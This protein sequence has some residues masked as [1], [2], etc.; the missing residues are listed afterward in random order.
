MKS[1]INRFICLIVG[2]R[3]DSFVKEDELTHLEFFFSKCIRC[4]FVAF[5]FKVGS[6]LDKAYKKFQSHEPAKVK[7]GSNETNS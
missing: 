1:P 5:K 7:S 2:H 3:M 4:G 6:A